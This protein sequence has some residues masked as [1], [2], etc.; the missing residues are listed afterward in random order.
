MLE[1]QYANLQER[2]KAT[3]PK[4][5]SLLDVKAGTAG[6]ARRLLAPDQVAISFSLPN[7]GELCAWLLDASGV[8]N[9]IDL[10]RQRSF[11][12]DIARL[13]DFTSGA[14]RPGSPDEEARLKQGLAD[15]LLKP[16]L[17][18]ASL[19]LANKK[20]WIII[21]D[22]D[23]ALLPFDT[24]PVTGPD[25]KTRPLIEVAEISIVQSWSVYVLLKER[26]AEY[27]KLTRPKSMFAMG[28]AVYKPSTHKTASAVTRG[29]IQVASRGWS[30]AG[31]LAETRAP[32]AA[33]EQHAMQ[34]LKWE[35]LPG[36]AFEVE[37]VAKVFG[38]GVDKYVDAQASEAGLQVLNKAGKLTDYRYLLFSAH[39]YLASN[40]ALTSLVLSLD[41]PTADADG[42]VTA[43]EWPAYNVKSDLIVLS[44]CDTGVGKTLAG[45]G[46]MGLPYV[47]FVAGNKNTLL[48]LWPVNDEV[49]AE[50]MTR[51]FTRLKNGESQVSALTE[52]KREFAADPAYSDP[53][54]WAAFVLYGV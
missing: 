9:F 40:P 16:L 28:N 45:E 54:F 18:D 48:T 5:A 4:Y 24:L 46:V 30:G 51:F 38:S 53:R 29:G 37:A 23:L 11:G 17:A 41:K 33:A 20:R 44:A 47:L 31:Y 34:N 12:A 25:G 13:R 27:S 1:G 14:S 43:A 7:S 52:V 26:E 22:G 42:Y 3:Y 35:N 50:F 21:P 19:G 15:I 6:D 49:T 8:P 32:N 39:G 10:D 36:T 2:L